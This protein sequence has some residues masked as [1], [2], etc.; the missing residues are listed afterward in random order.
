MTVPVVPQ[1]SLCATAPEDIERKK[2][3]AQRLAELAKAAALEAAKAEEEVV[4]MR[5]SNPEVQLDPERIDRSATIVTD[6]LL[7]ET[8]S[9]DEAM[10][11]RSPLRWIGGVYPAVALSF[12]AL[13]TPAQK[14]RQL[15][16]ENVAASG[17]TLDFVIDTA[18]NTNTINAQVAGPTAQGGLELA[19]V[20]SVD[21]GVGAGGSIGGGATY[22]LGTA[23]LADLPK[24]ERVPF[25]SG[26]TATALP[27]A[28]PAAAG[29]L[30]ISFLHS[31]A[32]GV[33]FLW[34]SQPS[35]TPA[36]GMVNTSPVSLMEVGDPPAI[37][38]Y[39]DAR[40]VE[41]NRAGMCAVDVETL[42]ESGL[43]TVKLLI[44]GVAVR[45][46]LDT[47]SPVT[48][49][50]GAA[51]SLVG[52]GVSKGGDGPANEGN[53]FARFTSGVAAA[54]AAARGDLLTV[55]GAEGPVQLKR[56]QEE[57]SLALS[58]DAEFGSDCRPYVGDLPGLDALGGLGA[59]AGPAAILGTDVLRRRPRLVIT[60]ERIYV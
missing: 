50:N 51:A 5:Q 58:D 31:F 12:P 28:A 40:G 2:Q 60:K 46:L 18:A 41:A 55:A 29:L 23:E 15:T 16:G 26:L 19:Q 13:A 56:T 38:F 1:I 35:T 42:T 3:K 36:G 37:L 11:L 48:V 44:N 10:V 34:G 7:S 25:I 52:L 45:A 6:P 9:Q 30:G 4:Q 49:L 17:V 20:G 21:S 59:G 27:V 8:A 53:L 54:Q 57:V 39:G 47:G 33:E 43:P 24:D 22:S 14:A 32:G